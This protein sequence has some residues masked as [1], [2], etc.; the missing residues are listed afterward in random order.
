MS[1]GTIQN[2]DLFVVPVF[3][4]AS[5]VCMPCDIINHGNEAS[6]CALFAHHA[7]TLRCWEEKESLDTVYKSPELEIFWISST[8][9]TNYLS[10][11][12][13]VPGPIESH[14]LYWSSARLLQWWFFLSSALSKLISRYVTISKSS[15]SVMA[16]GDCHLAM[17]MTIIAVCDFMLRR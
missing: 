2:C 12:L 3:C 5:V 1:V 10:C 11:S 16:R 6:L 8:L 15:N 17:A 14:M 4:L 7:L 9:Y 13:L